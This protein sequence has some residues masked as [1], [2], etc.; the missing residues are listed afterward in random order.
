MRKIACL[1]AGIG[2]TCDKP[3]LYYSAKMLSALGCEIVPVPY[4]GFES[5]VKGHPDRMR[6]ILSFEKELITRVK[7][8][9]L[10]CN[11]EADAALTAWEGMN[12]RPENLQGDKY[13]AQR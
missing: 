12:R 1:F 10:Q 4:G 7:F 6:A 3:L 5:G 9:R 11:M 13:E 2:Y 8:Y